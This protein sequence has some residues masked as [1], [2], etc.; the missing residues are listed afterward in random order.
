MLTPKE[1]YEEYSKNP[2][3]YSHSSPTYTQLDASVDI[4]NQLYGNAMG[5]GTPMNW[6]RIINFFKQVKYPCIQSAPGYN[7]ILNTGKNKLSPTFKFL[8]LLDAEAYEEVQPTVRAGTSYSVRNCCDLSRAC[9]FT[10]NKTTSRW[11]SRMATEYLEYYG[12]SSLPDCLFLCGPDLVHPIV[13]EYFRAPGYKVNASEPIQ[14]SGAGD[15][16]ILDDAATNDAGM[17]CFPTANGVPG[18][19]HFCYTPPE[20]TNAICTS[21]NECPAD[22]I[23]GEITDPSNPCCH[24]GSIYYFNQCC[25]TADKAVSDRLTDWSLWI[26]S[27]DGSFDGTILRGRLGEVLRHVGILERKIY[28]GYANFSTQCSGQNPP[29]TLDDLFFQYFQTINGWNYTEHKRSDDGEIQRARTI[30]LVLKASV[31]KASPSTDSLWMVDRIKDLLYNGYG[32][33]LLT[34]VG[35]NNLKDSTGVSYPDRV[36]YHTYNIIGYDDT[37]IDYDECVYVLQLPFGKWNS[38]GDPTWGPLPAGSFLVTESHLRCLVNY[39]PTSDFYGCRQEICINSPIRDCS[40][41]TIIRQLAGCGAGLE[42]RCDPY[43]C[44]PQQRACGFV[45]AVSLSE[46]F[47]KQDLNYDQFYP[48]QHWKDKL[49]TQTL[50]YK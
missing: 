13:S 50:Y 26:K 14:Y 44:T 11:F 39:Y 5:A 2:C 24:R 40:D 45:F 6:L 37:K 49:K 41:P 16:T 33:M 15:Q 17:T 48:I 36:F 31:F 23:S 10:H 47:P 1:L 34:N 8:Q 19:S 3:T 30:S 12:S 25:N 7:D 29:I 27:D 9:Y 20:S 43:Y 22:P 32:V 18:A 4:F 21:C 38:G 35:F 42:G 28:H 46:G